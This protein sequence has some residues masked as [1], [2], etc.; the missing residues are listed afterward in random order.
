MNGQNIFS[1]VFFC[2]QCVMFAL[3]KFASA[4]VTAIDI[5]ELDILLTRTHRGGA[6]HVYDKCKMAAQPGKKPICYS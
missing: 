6:I 5:G 3:I 4:C 2:S 1:V